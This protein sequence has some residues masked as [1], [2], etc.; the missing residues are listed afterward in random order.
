M[1]AMRRAALVG[2]CLLA[3]PVVQAAGIKASVNRNEVAVGDRLSLTL[4]VDGR[5]MADPELPDLSAFDV[6]PQGSSTQVQ[7]VNGRMSSSVAHNYVLVAKKAGAFTIGAAKIE[8]DGQVHTSQPFAVRVVAADAQPSESRDLYMTAKVSKSEA[9]VGEQLLYVLKIFQRVQLAQA[10]LEPLEFGGFLLEELGKETSYDAT[11]GGVAYRV[12]ELRR[13]LFPQ[14]A[15]TLTVP[16][17]RLTASV[18]VQKRRRG[19]D[20][21]DGMF[22]GQ[23]D[24]FFGRAATETRT[25]STAAT[26]VVVKALPARP[27]GFSGAVGAFTVRSTISNAAPKVGESTTLTIVVGG[28]GNP[29]SIKEP[30][31]ALAGFK[32]YDDKPSVNIDKS[33]SGLSGTKTFTKA[34]VPLAPGSLVVP[35]VRLTFF[36]PATKAY[37]TAAT[38]PITVNVAPSAA[39]EELRLTELVTPTTGKV[40]VKV[41]ADDILPNYTRLDALALQT[42]TRSDLPLV[43]AAL[44]LPPLGFLLL[45]LSLRHRRRLTDDVAF[46]RG[47]AARKRAQA[48]LHTARRA[49]QGG[50]HDTAAA[51]ASRALREYVGDRLNVEGTA[52]TPADVTRALA[53]RKVP[54]ELT[55]EIRTLLD[56]C[57]AL[58][59]GATREPAAIAARAI[60]RARPVLE[61]LER[62]LRSS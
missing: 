15:G 46:R 13:A 24:D 35:A 53:G 57:E 19:A 14:E 5:V 18:V 27:P 1:T 26:A 21:F 29:Q 61:Q 41:L 55:T 3:S 7:I 31:L 45:F 4:T 8:I 12:T 39:R 20:P 44:G 28:S 54:A 10:S 38:E 11:V 25:L 30:E 50:D 60:D 36:N 51:L 6:Y 43:A 47:R 37:E 34:L 9:Y 58:H 62:A 22:G 32:T 52:L 56:Q 16:P 49:M 40:E 2:C 17:A 59:Y 48:T 42:V 23:L 33:G